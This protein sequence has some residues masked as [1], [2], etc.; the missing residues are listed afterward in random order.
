MNRGEGYLAKPY[1]AVRGART[2]KVHTEDKVRRRFRRLC[3][4]STS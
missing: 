2:K 1:Q 4:E 3:V